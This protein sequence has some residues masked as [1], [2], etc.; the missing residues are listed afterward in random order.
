MKHS[1]VTNLPKNPK[2]ILDYALKNSFNF[3]VD[4]KGTKDNPEIW[5]RQPSKLSFE[6]AFEINLNVSPS[7]Q[8]IISLTLSFAL[9]AVVFDNVFSITLSSIFLIYKI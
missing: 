4:E 2:K 3:W 6:E 7:P 1:I 8:N 5:R 9:L